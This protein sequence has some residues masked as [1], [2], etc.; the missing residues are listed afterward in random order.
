MESVL[1]WQ[2]WFFYDPRAVSFSYDCE[3][4]ERWLTIGMVRIGLVL[5]V[6]HTSEEQGNEEIIRII[7]A[8]KATRPE[9][10]GY[11]NQHKKS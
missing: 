2:G 11:E 8:R 7:L 5:A 9:T 6:A 3:A 4:E 10:E 1:S